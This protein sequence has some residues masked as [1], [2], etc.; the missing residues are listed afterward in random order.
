MVDILQIT[1]VGVV[2]FLMLGLGATVTVGDIVGLK[3]NPKPPLIGFISQFIFM[4]LMAF[5]LAKILDVP[6]TMGLSM[7]LIGCTPG[8]STSN[9]FSYFSRGDVSLSIAMTLVSNTAAFVMMPLLLLLY[10]PAFT[11]DGLEIPFANIAAGLLIVLIPVAIGMC[12]LSRSPETAKKLEKTSSSLGGIFIIAAMIAGVVQNSELF[13]SGFQLYAASILMAPCG[14]SCG[15]FLGYLSKLPK[16]QCRTIALETGI[17]NST[18]T[19]AVI[20]LSYPGGDAV[21]DQLQQDVLA[22]ALMY[23]MFLIVSG[24]LTSALFRY[25]SRNEEAEEE[26]ER[27]AQGK[28]VETGEM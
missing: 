4:P 10:G 24:V 2:F 14:Y 28:D 17:Q 21:A 20:M 27:K 5:L 15:Y 13:S 12:I 8:G 26:A 18:L 1:M 25:L 23:T 22:F 16:R 11:S 9:I 3:K 7:V 6:D 19:I